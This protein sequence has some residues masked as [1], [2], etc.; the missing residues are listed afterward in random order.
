LDQ[1]PQQDKWTAGRVEQ[2]DLEKDER[3]RDAAN[4]AAA[5]VFLD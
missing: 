2:M 1:C 4:A 5:L 3:A